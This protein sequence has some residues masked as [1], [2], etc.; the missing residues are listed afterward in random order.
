MA[1]IVAL[2]LMHRWPLY[3]FDIS[4]AF[5]LETLNE[6]VNI[7]QLHNFADPDHPNHVCCLQWSLYNLLC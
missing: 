4:N 2:A 1:T 3:Q 5:L 6:E 7:K